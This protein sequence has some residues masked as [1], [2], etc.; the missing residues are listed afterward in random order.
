LELKSSGRPDSLVFEEKIFTEYKGN[1]GYIYFFRYKQKKDDANWKL[2]TVGLV[3]L[4]AE[5]FEFV[6]KKRNNSTAI[7]SAYGLDQKVDF[8]GFT[9]TR[10]EEE[11]LPEE[12]LQNLLKK[13]LYSKR[14]SAREFYDERDD[15]DFDVT[16]PRIVHGN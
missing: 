5:Q 2:A 4:D 6:E 9:E 3:P 10:F 11:E 16:V 12:Q 15:K 13:L 14:R 8:T 7:R 1:K